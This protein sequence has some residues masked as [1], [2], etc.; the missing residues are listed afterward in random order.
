[1]YRCYV[2][3]FKKWKVYNYELWVGRKYTVQM[4]AL[5]EVVYIQA[6]IFGDQFLPSLKSSSFHIDTRGL[7]GQSI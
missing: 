3:T 2:D 6:Y 1:M 5:L 7:T 4:Y